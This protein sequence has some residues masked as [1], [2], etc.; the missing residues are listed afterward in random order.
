MFLAIIFLKKISD[1]YILQERQE[2]IQ[3]EIAFISVQR[4]T[5]IIFQLKKLKSGPRIS[6][7]I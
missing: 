7:M 6:C 1:Y 2:A 5:V 3:Q 4:V